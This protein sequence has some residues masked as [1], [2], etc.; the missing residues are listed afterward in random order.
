M[1]IT[2]VCMAGGL[3]LA[4]AAAANAAQ[5]YAFGDSLS[6]NGRV[7]RETGYD[8]PAIIGPN[9]FGAPG[10]YEGGLWS[11]SPNFTEVLPGVLGLSYDPSHGLAVGGARSVHQDPSP[12][13]SPDFAWGLPDQIDTFE[14]SFGV[15][16]SGDLVSLWIGYN[17][18]SAIPLAA[19]PSEQSAAIDVIVGNTIDAISRLADRGGSEFLVLNQQTYRPDG[20][21]ALASELNEKLGLALE[22]FTLQGLDIVYFDA[23]T[24]LQTLRGNPT[25]FGFVADAGT[26]ACNAVP[27]C[28]LDGAQTG[29]ENS[30]ISPEGIHLTGRANQLLAEA[31]AAD[32]LAP[33]PVPVPAAGWLLVAGLGAMGGVGRVLR[34]R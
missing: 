31:I 11:N 19:L 8:A 4:A 10:I 25:G 15:L 34:T 18:L 1:R 22:P 13:L 27:A 28:A 9:F 20:R 6:D 23:D 12:Q 5:F 30:Y 26:V 29:L 7:L 24:F 16:D 3:L 21:T 32:I 33:A 17:D 2:S 14:S